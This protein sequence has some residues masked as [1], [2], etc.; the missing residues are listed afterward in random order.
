M[1]VESNS[2]RHQVDESESVPKIK[3]TFRG[4][5]ERERRQRA[6]NTWLESFGRHKMSFSRSG[7]RERESKYLVKILE[8]E[9]SDFCGFVRECVKMRLNQT[10]VTT[11]IGVALWPHTYALSNLY[12][13]SWWPL[14]HLPYGEINNILKIY[15]FNKMIN[16]KLFIYLFIL[17]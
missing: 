16:F 12:S 1:F 8:A 15:Y 4:K 3:L 14:P 10:S 11:C 13:L 9:L 6:E 7:G 2:Q 5:R 17:I